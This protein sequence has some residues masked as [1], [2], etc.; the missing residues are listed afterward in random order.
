MVLVMRNRY[1]QKAFFY[2]TWITIAASDSGFSFPGWN[3]V[4]CVCKQKNM[5]ATQIYTWTCRPAKQITMSNQN[6]IF[7]FTYSNANFRDYVLISLNKW[8][9]HLVTRTKVLNFDYNERSDRQFFE[10]HISQFCRCFFFPFISRA[11]KKYTY[12]SYLIFLCYE[13]K[14][15]CRIFFWH[16]RARARIRVFHVQFYCTTIFFLYP[17]AKLYTFS[18]LV[19]FLMLILNI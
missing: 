14:S 4:K 19:I 3:C 18:F 8:Y 6:Q 12:T 15:M 13:Y 10:K 2:N 9:V 5:R 17:L 7:P 11:G 1:A 16:T